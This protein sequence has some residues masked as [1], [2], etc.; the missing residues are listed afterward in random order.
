MKEIGLQPSTTGE[1]GGKETGQ[2]VTHYLIP[3]GPVCPRVRKARRDQLS[4][5]LAICSVRWRERKKKA[6]SKTKY[7]C[8]TCAANAWAKPNTQLICGACY[9]EDDGEISVIM[10]EPAQ[11]GQ[12]AA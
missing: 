1:P 4:I 7:T 10:P 6:A 5:E 9:D 11:D 8:S 2:S 12:A 3:G